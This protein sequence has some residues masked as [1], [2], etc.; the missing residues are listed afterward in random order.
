MTTRN[1]P[2]GALVLTIVMVVK[3][4]VVG[5]GGDTA[6]GQGA[7]LRKPAQEVV[8]AIGRYFAKKGGREF[9]EEFTEFG[10]EAF[11]RKVTERT[12]RE[13]GA[14]A[15]ELLVRKAGTH[16]PD[17]LRAA[18]NAVS[19]PR[20]LKAVDDLPEDMAGPAIRRLSAGADGRILAEAVEQYGPKALRAELRHPGVGGRL[21][22]RLGEDG[23]QLSSKVST[24][25][26]IT[27]SRHADNIV[28]LPASQKQR[29]IDLLRN[30]TDRMVTFMG[31]FIEKNPGKVLFTVAG[32]AVVLANADKVLGGEGEIVIGPD[33]KPVYVPQPGMIERVT[34]GVVNRVLAVV[35][36]LVALA[37]AV[38]LGIKL[39]FRY[40][41]ARLQHGVAVGKLNKSSLNE[42]TNQKAS[43]GLDRDDA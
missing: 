36:P 17:A 20:L 3:L 35:M 5:G 42:D 24:D 19:I 38:W 11:V 31:R 23:V 43:G 8:E 25:Q 41:L 1:R 21:V 37:G 27:I 26:A 2:E 16:G 6:S 13:G 12:L 30:D 15:F 33:G 10:G 9:T 4:L 29:V 18:D 14:D 22:S 40:R 32:T 28:D 34:M 39:W 7:V